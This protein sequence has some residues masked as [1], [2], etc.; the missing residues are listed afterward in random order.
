V[1]SSI[2]ESGIGPLTATL[3]PLWREDVN[4]TIAEATLHVP[5]DVQHVSTGKLGEHSEHMGFLLAELQS[6]ARQHPGATW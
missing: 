6:I 5:A 3:E 1:E 2:A 4:A